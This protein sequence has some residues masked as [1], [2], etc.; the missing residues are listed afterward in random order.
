MG[1]QARSLLGDTFLDKPGVLLMAVE[2]KA[3][4]AE[5]LAGAPI[6]DAEDTRERILDAY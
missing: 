5:A 1:P 3:V 4:R 2:E 6:A